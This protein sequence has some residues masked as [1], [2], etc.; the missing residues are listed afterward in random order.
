MPPATIAGAVK[1]AEEFCLWPLFQTVTL[2][3]SLIVDKLKNFSEKISL[4]IQRLTC[5][6]A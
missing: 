6:F 5:L 4:A 1:V 3:M 2:H